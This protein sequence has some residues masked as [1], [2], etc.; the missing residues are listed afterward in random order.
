MEEVVTAEVINFTPPNGK[1]ENIRVV[2]PKRLEE[3]YNLIKK[4][5]CRLTSEVL[6][7]GA[8]SITVE[9]PNLGD[10]LMEIVF[11]TKNTQDHINKIIERFD[12]QE[13]IEWKNNVEM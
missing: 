3:K 11:D 2:I 4:H 13:F 5:K 8:I 12:E 7:T 9:E 6:R 10:F 1:K